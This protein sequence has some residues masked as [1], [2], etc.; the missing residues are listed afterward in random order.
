MKTI[1]IVGAGF[2]GAVT[3][4]LLLKQSHHQPVR[5]VLANGSGRVAR[6]MA[7]GTQSPEHTLNVPA[8][9]MSAFDDAPGHFLDFARS[10]DPRINAT[11]FVSRS[12]YG[13]YLEWLLQQAEQQA[14][15]STTKL[16]RLHKHV[17]RI[18][19]ANSSVSVTFECGER[20]QVEKVVL[21]LGHFQSSNP[22]IDNMTFYESARY[23]RDPW[24]MGKLESIG[25]DDPVLLLGTGLTAVDIA[26]TLLNR[27]PRR[28]IITVSRRG[29]LPQHHRHDSNPPS[30]SSTVN[31]IWGNAS[32]VRDQLRRFRMYSRRLAMTGRD[33]REGMAL[34]RP[35]TAD[36]WQGYAEE[37]RKRFLRHVQPYWDSH[38]H[39]LAPA[40]FERFNEA[41]RAGVIRTLA[42]RIR[43]FD[44][45]DNGITA[46]MQPRGSGQ[47][48]NVKAA[49]VINCTGPCTNLR[50]TENPLVNQLLDDGL[51]RVDNL[52]LGL[53]VGHHCATIDAHGHTS[54][55]VFYIGPWLKANYWEAT[56]VPDLRKFAQRL[57]NQILISL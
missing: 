26:M 6:G 55:N 15:L 3:A 45:N 8:G 9:N 43:S 4:A 42:A 44:E 38:R 57:A 27:N 21:A 50:N 47:L 36:I 16:E 29:L 22:S 23:I 33:W 7:Y 11:T 46:T 32:T 24:D 34:L 54:D 2:S 49:W 19:P 13:D 5:V 17:V 51:I 20:M 40:V 30:T 18:A 53:D 35:L 41:L 14:P 52:G 1:L 12:L 28:S 56:A 31:S 37:E 10:R 25:I 48:I 39:R